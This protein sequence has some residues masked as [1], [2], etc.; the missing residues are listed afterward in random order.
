MPFLSIFLTSSTISL[1]F[2]SS[3]STNAPKHVSFTLMSM[4]G[5]A[6]MLVSSLIIDKILLFT[7]PG[8]IV[9]SGETKISLVSIT[10][11]LLLLFTSFYITFYLF[12][13]KKKCY[14]SANKFFTCASTCT[15]LKCRCSIAPTG[16]VAAQVPHP[17]HIAPTTITLFSFSSNVNAP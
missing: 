10:I 14:A 15:F 4:P 9:E 13:K 6:A 5:P 2:F 3:P 1:T 7:C 16:Q 12:S 17:L 8:V 11:S